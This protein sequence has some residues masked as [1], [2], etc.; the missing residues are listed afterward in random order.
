M[1]EQTRSDADSSTAT[2]IKS[3]LDRTFSERTQ[4]LAATWGRRLIFAGV[5][6]LLVYQLS[7]VGWI[8]ILQSLPTHPLFYLIFVGMYLGLPIAETFIYRLIWG[9]RFRESFP[10][11]LQK[12]VFNKDVLNY[13]GE[14]RLYLWAKQTLDRPGRL[15]LRDIKDNTVIS[16]LTSMFIAVTLLSTFLFT[17]MLPFEALT[18][19]LDTTWVIGGGLCLVLLIALA[20]R[21]RKS[22]ISLPANKT[23]KLFGL[24]AG[25]LL[26][27]QTLQILQWMVVMPTVPI[28]AWF[29]FLATQII[30]NLIPLLPQKDLVVLAASPDIANW[31]GVSESGIAGMLLVSSVLDKVVNFILFTYLSTRYKSTEFTD[32]D[33][34]EEAS[35]N[36]NRPDSE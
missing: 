23:W 18:G 3:W 22:V 4:K 11:M 13:S 1:T 34:D 29:T 26:F 10:I 7:Q 17:G 36:A 6:T 35:V 15:I 31:V 19:W 5:L 14:A 30:A 16:S 12:R 24:H 20:L 28:A 9:V 33:A 25:R 32:I 2:G 27:V 8:N 21:F